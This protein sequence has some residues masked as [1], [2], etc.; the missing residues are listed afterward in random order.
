MF[1]LWLMLGV[2]HGL[3]IQGLVVVPESVF[4]PVVDSMDT[5]VLN[6]QNLA[7]RIDVLLTSLDDF[8]VIKAPVDSQFQFQ[9][10]DLALGDYQLM[11]HLHDFHFKIDRYRI[12]VGDEVVRAIPDGLA[13]ELDKLKV[14]DVTEPLEFRAAVAK[15]Y[16]EKTSGGVSDIIMS[17][18]FGFIF[19]NRLYTIMFTVML[20]ITVT[21]YL[22]EWINPDFA[23]TFR[24]LR[25]EAVNPT[26]QNTAQITDRAPATNPV[27]SGAK[28][29]KRKVR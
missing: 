8:T 13:V 16:Y 23:E 14:F 26:S 27:S 20:A 24:E 11:V 12:Q 7:L 28:I 2:C 29:K 3:A 22:L 6:G 18:P 10:D 15:D 25:E 4:G 19:R 1:F 9:F 17:S 5:R 21:P